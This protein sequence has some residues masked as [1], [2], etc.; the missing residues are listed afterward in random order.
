MFQFPHLIRKV[1]GHVNDIH[2]ARYSAQTKVAG[3]EEVGC[4]FD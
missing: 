4:L 2:A 1:K 3:V